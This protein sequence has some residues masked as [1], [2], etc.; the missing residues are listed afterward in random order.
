MK[1][2]DLGAIQ[3]SIELHGRDW[4]EASDQVWEF[5]ELRF[6]EKQSAE[7][8][9]GLLEKAGFVIERK[10]AGLETAFVASYGQ[11]GPVIGI[12]GEYDALPGLSQVADLA[13]KKPMIPGAPGHGCGHNLLGMAAV[14]AAVAAADHLKKYPQSGTIRFYGCPAEEGGGGKVIMVK[15]GVFQDVDAAITWHPS[16][17]HY[18]QNSSTLATRSL[19]FYFHGKSA[20]ASGNPHDGRSALDAVELTNVGSNYLREHIPSQARVHYA[21]TNTG[22][23]APNV[24]QAESS[25]RYQIRSPL[26][27]Q[28]D[29]VYERVCN[30]AR[31]AALMTDT[32]LEIVDESRYLNVLPNRAMESVMQRQLELLG[33]PE[34][35]EAELE[36]ARAMRA[37]MTESE[38]TRQ[39]VPENK[40]KELCD[41]L[42]PASSGPALLLAS[43]DVGDVSW[44]VPTVQYWS[45]VWAVGTVAHTWQATAQGKSSFAHKGMLQAGRVMAATAVALIENAGRLAEAKKEFAG[46][47]A[48]AGSGK[49]GS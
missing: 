33:V 11:G 45:A 46:L 20:H 3:Q 41:Q 5:A 14:A 43:T 12:L 15:E 4:I 19:T 32:R 48:E 22:G 38:R 10:A 6:E 13:E 24:V 16:D 26:A 44:V 42:A 25:V 34:V 17:A 7:L 37:T 30:I 1:Q 49:G 2:T 29:E 39:E 31:G 27:G 47:L 40:G 36:F 35:D 18:V 21:I 23:N 28:V 8:L 9:M